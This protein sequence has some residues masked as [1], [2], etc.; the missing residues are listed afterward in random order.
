MDVLTIITIGERLLK[1]GM[2]AFAS[3]RQAVADAGAGADILAKLDALYAAR[4]AREH[5]ILTG[6]TPA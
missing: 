1:I 3:Y 5:A 2:G 4:I 6:T